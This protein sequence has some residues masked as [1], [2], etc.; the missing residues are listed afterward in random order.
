[1]NEE[2]DLCYA[3][4]Q[5]VFGYVYL[6]CR[7]GPIGGGEGDVAPMWTNERFRGDVAGWLRGGELRLKEFNYLDTCIKIQFL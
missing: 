7:H 1:M 6:I 4:I 3:V 5:F 2:I